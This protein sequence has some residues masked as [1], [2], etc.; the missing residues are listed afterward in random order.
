MSAFEELGVMP[1][2]IRAVEEMGWN[3]PSD[4]QAEA[5]PLILGGGDVL[6]A[7]ATGSGKTGAFCLPALQLVH[8]SLSSPV[9][10]G[11]SSGKLGAPVVLSDQDCDSFFVTDGYRCQTRLDQWGGGRANLGVKRG[12]F[13]FEA[14]LTDEGLSRFG[15]VTIAGNLALGL[16]KQSFGYGGTGKKS[17]AGTFE[18]YGEPFGKG[19]VIGVCIDLEESY[20]ISFCK[21]G[22]DLGVAFVI[23]PNLRGSSF[24]PGISL[25]NAEALLNFG[26]R[27]SQRIPAGFKWLDDALVS[28]TSLSGDLCEGKRTPRVIIMEP[29][30]ELAEQVFEEINKFRKYL[31]HPQV[32]PMLCIGGE[33]NRK[34]LQQLRRGVDI[35]VATPG[36]LDDIYNSGELDL[37]SMMFF[38]LDEADSLLD[39]GNSELVLKLY[40]N[41]IRQKQQMQVLLFSATL[42]SPSIAEM[43]HQV[44]KNAVWVDLK[45]RDSV[46]ETV[47]FSKV[48]IDPAADQDWPQVPTD[49]VHVRD[50][51]SPSKNTPESMSE[52]IKRLKIKETVRLVQKYK[53]EQCMIF[54]RTKVDCDNLEQHFLKLGDARKFSGVRETGKD[55][56]FSCVVLH[57]DRR[58]DER[59]RNL[60][61]F[62][63]GFVRFLICTDVAARGIDVSGL[64]FM[65]MMSLPDQSEDFIHRIG[66]VGRQDC[67][68]LAIALCSTA[69]EKVWYHS[70]PSRGKNCQNTQVA[71]HGGCCRWFDDREL[72]E[73]IE[74]R[75]GAPVPLLEELESS[76]SL[77]V[78]GEGSSSGVAYGQSR[79]KNEATESMRQLYEKLQPSV[80]ELAQYEA[81]MQSVYLDYQVMF[82]GRA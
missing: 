60:D 48:I 21:N 74:K 72:L 50:N 56:L 19:D 70:C 49:G 55:N 47:H 41:V 9:A 4:I 44:T 36:K 23:P 61:A 43:A 10:G 65:I 7:A 73:V 51:A 2:L 14:A 62:K 16:D 46:P 68:G 71:E 37:S 32:S 45:G 34:L 12:K 22:V 33:E 58:P 25:K 6:A 30:K 79:I 18:D 5:I 53:M 59:R 63:Q 57:G 77:L 80:L 82:P 8:E 66:R 15:W 40:R 54:C 27:K 69:P 52:G 31:D 75:I 28:E 29:T 13:Y 76:G 64:P 81:E 67:M 24:F 17:N 20:S 78:G 11:S 3:L 1:E 38:I 35:V 39:S 26:Q 42:H